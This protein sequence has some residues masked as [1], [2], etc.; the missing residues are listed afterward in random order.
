MTA[1]VW[2]PAGIAFAFVFQWGPQLIPGVLLGSMLAY[3]PVLSGKGLPLWSVCAAGLGVGAGAA[4]QALVGAEWI[5]RLL[6]GS[7]ALTGVDS[8]LRFVLLPGP[9]TCV[10]GSFVAM[11]SLV[12]A[13]ALP[14]AQANL[15]WLIGWVGD[16]IGVIVFAPLTLMLL[17]AQADAWQGRRWK[18]AIPSLLVTAITLGLFLQSVDLNKRQSQLEL[19]QLANQ[20]KSALERNLVRHQAVL[21]GVGSLFDA[22]GYVSRQEFARFTLNSLQHIDGLEAISW[23]PH[24]RSEQLEK[25]VRHQREEEDLPDYR[26]VERSSDGAL[27]PVSPR[28]SHVVVAYIEPLERHRTALGFDI[29][30]N[31]ARATAID[32]ARRSGVVQATAPI[33]LVQEEGTQKGILLLLPVFEAA[34]P[35][36]SDA[37]PL[38]RKLRGFTVGV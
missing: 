24:L 10:V 34:D 2:A 6:G 23:N 11:K 37:P 17:P 38:P 1:P 36:A 26:I 31:A 7:P 20:A 9:C 19:E 12:I 35:D 8:I 5:R 18:L 25:F 21:E 4:V 22:I 32:L 16:S 30:S 13:G 14:P 28:A 29:Q 3:L 33:T 15:S 27:K